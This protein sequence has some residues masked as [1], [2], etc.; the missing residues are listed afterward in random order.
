MIKT[1]VC[2][3]LTELDKQVNDFMVIQKK[4]LPVRT[5]SFVVLVNDNAVVYHK[6]TIFFDEKFSQ[7]ETVSS[8]TGDGMVVTEESVSS[9]KPEKIGALWL[10]DDK[11]L[12]G[13]FR[14]AR[15]KIPAEV[16]E[17]LLV[18]GVKEDLTLTMKNEQVRVIRNKFKETKKQPDFVIF[19]KK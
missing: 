17:Q 19:E 13:T 3:H 7:L 4:N 8:N 16:R 14:D 10:Q 9:D 1:L 2:E 12:S 15:I 18:I 5:E 11:S 6:A